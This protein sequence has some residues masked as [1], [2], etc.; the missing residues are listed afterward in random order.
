M[1]QDSAP[2][3]LAFTGLTKV[4][5]VKNKQGLPTNITIPLSSLKT[6]VFS[7]QLDKCSGY[8]LRSSQWAM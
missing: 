4:R 6:K 7:N 2:L 8:I 5:E 1:K 3:M